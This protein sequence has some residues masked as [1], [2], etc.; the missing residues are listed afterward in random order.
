MILIHLMTSLILL[1]MSSCPGS[2]KMTNIST[3][4]KDSDW[5]QL[6]GN[7]EHDGEAFNEVKPPLTQLWRSSVDHAP[8]GNL[9]A[10]LKQYKL[11]FSD[12][13]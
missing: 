9:T 13:T 1:A 7:A 3:I 10:A 11:W 2:I 12:P 6:G 8:N 4:N 5:T